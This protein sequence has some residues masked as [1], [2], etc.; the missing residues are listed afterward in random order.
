MHREGWKL[1]P[2]APL[3]H[4]LKNGYRLVDCANSINFENINFTLK[5]EKKRKKG[6]V[7]FEEEINN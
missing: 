6:I 5:R 7:F 2:T 1:N 3:V 4:P